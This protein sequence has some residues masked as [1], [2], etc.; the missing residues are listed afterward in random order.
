MDRVL[1]PREIILPADVERGGRRCK[2]QQDGRIADEIPQVMQ[3]VVRS[4]GTQVE[5]RHVS[6]SARLVAIRIQPRA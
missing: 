2:R 1:S 3:R 6:P 5:R 4:I